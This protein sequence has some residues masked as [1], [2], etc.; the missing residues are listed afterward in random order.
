MSRA[1][2]LSQTAAP[3]QTTLRFR[4]QINGTTHPDFVMPGG[5]VKDI[6]RGAAGVFAIQLPDGVRPP[7][8]TGLVGMVMGDS[9]ATLGLIVQCE[10]ADYVVA[11]GVLTVR[12]VDTY[13][14]ATPAAADPVDNDWVYIN[15]TFQ[16]RTQGS[17]EVAI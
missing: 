5:L 2:Y 14:D 8:F 9:G 3:D 4:F 16:T 15:A 7:V 10:L 1:P 17:A 13:T 11:T 12:T 6:T